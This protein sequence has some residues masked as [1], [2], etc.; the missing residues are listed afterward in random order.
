MAE[1]E[2]QERTEQ[3]TGKRLQD[4][5]EKGQVPRSRDL[6]TTILLLTASLALLVLGP[7]MFDELTMLFR[8]G[9]S[10]PRAD[11]FSSAALL[12]AMVAD[13]RVMLLLLAPFLLLTVVAALL[14]PLA[15]GGW[16]FSG[17]T[18]MFDLNKLNPVKGLGK[19]FSTQGLVELV[20]SIAKV[21][22][23]GS[24][25]VAM[26]WHFSD[27]ILGLAYEPLEVAAVHGGHLIGISMLVLSVALG[28]I[29]GVDVPFQIWN[30][31]RQ[32]KMT[33]QEIKDEFK[34]TEGSPEVRGRIRR[35]R[36][37]IAQRRMMEAV[38]K[39]DVVVTNP[40]HYAVALRYEQ[41]RMKAPR[42]VAKGADL[43]ALKIRTIAK[44]HGVELF[45]APP[46]ARALYHS[47]KL[48][49]E[50]PAVLYV[51]VAQILAYVYHLK[52]ARESGSSAPE[53]PGDLPVPDDLVP[54]A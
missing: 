3:A 24:V 34:E 15:L 38:P 36:R 22:V 50:V 30:H 10:I 14:G 7:R 11:L 39:A 46:L 19:L 13:L 26:L 35:M 54:G 25:A 1:S 45:S 18:L 28:L 12:S 23:V 16:T 43:I 6:N 44:A 8:R 21:V 40:T 9:L 5:R 48:D 27:Q 29:A 37:E 51:A 47:T 52:Q 17:E 42:V 31:R 41:D 49:Q 32:L 33:R 53:P 4:A 2:Q 20:K